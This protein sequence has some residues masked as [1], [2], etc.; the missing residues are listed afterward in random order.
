MPKVSEEYKEE[1]KNRILESALRCF[2]EKGYEATIIDDIVRESNLSKGAIYNYFNSKEEIYLQ[3]LQGRTKD[4]FS[5]VESE[6]HKR[7]SA[8]DKL[9][10]LFERF[11]NQPLTD[12]RRKSMRLY[13]EFW[14]YSARQEDLKKLME[15]RYLQFTGFLKDIIKE[16]QE[17]GEFNEQVDS[18][19]ISQIFWALRDGNVLHYSLLGEEEQ[20]KKTWEMIEEFFIGCLTTP[21]N[22]E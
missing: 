15:E 16:G 9:R 18:E 2:G 22:R 21:K 8:T 1:K 13:T 17:T 19:F 6:Y 12:E 14:L 7:S 11:Q 3:L 10:F 4:F 5:E 20:Y